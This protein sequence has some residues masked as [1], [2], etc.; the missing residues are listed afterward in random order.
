MVNDGCDLLCREASVTRFC[1]MLERLLTAVH[2]RKELAMA[3]NWFDRLY[4]QGLS[5][6]RRW[7]DWLFI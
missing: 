2:R 3:G 4:L 6:R 5:K 1:A 7:P